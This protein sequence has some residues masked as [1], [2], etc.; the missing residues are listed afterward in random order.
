MAK[1]TAV[2]A[3]NPVNG[4][5]LFNYLENFYEHQ[6]PYKVFAVATSTHIKTNS[7][8]HIEADDVIANLK[9]H[10]AD[11]DA[12]IFA[13]GDATPV[14]AQHAGEKHIQDMLA[15]IKEFAD[16][17]KLMIGHCAAAMYF[18]M[19]G[20]ASGKK[21]AIHPLAKAALSKNTALDDKTSIDGNFYTAQCEH[22]VAALMPAILKAL[23]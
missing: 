12:L 21:F 1:K 3:L 15:V 22:D 2:L 16:A 19:S 7:G 13:C 14:F 5:G 9:G 17:G 10:A 6:I 11:Y 4:Y 8:I 18:E 23:R 20:A